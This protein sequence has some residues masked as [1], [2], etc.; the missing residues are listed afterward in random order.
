VAVP[1]T[2]ITTGTPGL[3][4]GVPVMVML[5]YR[6]LDETKIPVKNPGET[7]LLA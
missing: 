5:K 3:S 4:L 1:V 6:C 7:A 2:V